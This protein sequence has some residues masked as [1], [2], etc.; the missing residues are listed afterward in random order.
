V[1]RLRFG[2]VWCCGGRTYMTI[3]PRGMSWVLVQISHDLF[4]EVDQ[5]LRVTTSQHIAFEGFRKRKWTL[6][7]ERPR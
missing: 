2:Q 7:E 5:S 1:T 3:A 6:V 4:T